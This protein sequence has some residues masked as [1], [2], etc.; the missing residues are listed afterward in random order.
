MPRC[1]RLANPLALWL[2]SSR[3]CGDCSVSGAAGVVASTASCLISDLLS[4]RW[5]E[6]RYPG[7]ASDVAKLGE[8]CLGALNPTGLN[9]K[10]EFCSGLPQG[11]LGVSETHLSARGVSKFRLGLKMAQASHSLLTVVH[12]FLRARTATRLAWVSCQSPKD[13]G[14][15]LEMAKQRIVRSASGPRFLIKNS[16]C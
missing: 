16:T 5:G 15:I 4:V 14:T 1:P 12:V 11:I 10:A 9:G 7:P 8:F 3:G 13:T 2:G 6:A